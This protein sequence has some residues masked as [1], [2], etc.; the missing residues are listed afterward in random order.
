MNKYQGS[1][2][3]APVRDRD[4][5]ATLSL[6][7]LVSE[8]HAPQENGSHQPAASGSLTENTFPYNGRRLQGDAFSELR[9]TT[10]LVVVD[11]LTAGAAVPLALL[12]LS[13]ISGQPQNSLTHFGHN[14]VGDSIFPA[15]VVLALA[16][17]G[18][19]RSTRFALRTSVFLYLK[20][21]ILAIGTG[22]VLA[23]GAGV[24]IHIGSGIAEPNSTQLLLAV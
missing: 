17:S 14:R 8:P 2:V 15:A 20:D 9:H 19:Y 3:V 24:L 18:S 12:L 11:F 7:T 1:G 21:L 13:V 10:T 4:D 16:A 6:P 5:S 23:I 22:C